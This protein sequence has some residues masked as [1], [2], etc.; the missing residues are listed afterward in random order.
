MAPWFGIIVPRELDSKAVCVVRARRALA[1]ADVAAGLGRR[2]AKNPWKLVHRTE[3]SFNN[4]CGSSVS[5]PPCGFVGAPS[6]TACSRMVAHNDALQ[7]VLERT[8]CTMC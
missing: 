6:K 2:H 7:E 1:F 4:K 5:E 3:S 8:F